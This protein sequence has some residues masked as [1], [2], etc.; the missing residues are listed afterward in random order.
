MGKGSNGQAPRSWNP[1][2]TQKVIRFSPVSFAGPGP[3]ARHDVDRSSVAA[4]RFGPVPHDYAVLDDRVAPI[5]PLGR[6]VRPQD[7]HC[8]G[9]PRSTFRALWWTSPRPGTQKPQDLRCNGPAKK[10]VQTAP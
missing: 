1:L 3:F 7:P 6:R 5:R 10:I 4:G 8:G 2:F 9:R